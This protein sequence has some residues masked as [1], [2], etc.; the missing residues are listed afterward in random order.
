MLDLLR[1]AGDALAYS[2]TGIVLMTLGYLLVDVITPG[3]LREQI[4]VHRN[5]NAAILLSSN[6]IGVAI[7]LTTAIWTSAGNI[8]AGTLDD[9]LASALLYGIIGLAVMALAFFLLDLLTPGK[10]GQLL[11]EHEAHPAVWVTASMHLAIGGIVAAAL[12]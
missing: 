9:G 6:L 8:A 5:K 7:I 3:N 12:S 4:W 1:D 10:L 2:L 11:V